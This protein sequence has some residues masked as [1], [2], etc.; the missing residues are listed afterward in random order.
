MGMLQAT[1]KMYQSKP[2]GTYTPLSLGVQRNQ[3]ATLPL[4][5]FVYQLLPGVPL[6]PYLGISSFALS[7]SALAFSASNLA[8][9]LV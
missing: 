3:F 8:V 2:R 4:G 9:S 5:I 7:A 6:F 1:Q